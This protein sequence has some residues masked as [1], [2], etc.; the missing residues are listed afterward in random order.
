[1]KLAFRFENGTSQLILMPENQRDKT[2]IDL[3]VDGKNDIRL[4]PTNSDGI[5]LEFTASEAK[6]I[7][8]IIERNFHPTDCMCDKCVELI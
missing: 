1:M 2:Y 3:C 8:P 4:K 6:S 5:T 7:V